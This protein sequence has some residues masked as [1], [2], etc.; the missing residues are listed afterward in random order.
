MPGAPVLFAVP[1]RQGRR[2]RGLFLQNQPVGLP[3]GAEAL[4]QV[5]AAAA[6]QRQY[7]L[8][9]GPGQ[10]HAQLPAHG[11]DQPASDGLVLP[12][13]N[14]DGQDSRAVRGLRREGLRFPAEVLVFLPQQLRRRRDPSRAAGRNLLQQ[15]QDLQAQ[16]VAEEAGILIAL[17]LHVG[18]AVPGHIGV[19]L[20]P[21]GFQEWA[22]DPSPHRGDAAQ[23]LESRSPQKV[24]EGRLGV[25]L[26]VVSGGDAGRAHVTG[27]SIQEGV[28][29]LPG[30]VLD[31][32]ALPGGKV[33]HVPRSAGQGDA[34]LPAPVPDKTLVP[35]RCGP[36]AV[37]EMG[38]GDLKAPLP[39]QGGEKVEH[40]H[41]VPPAGHG[42]QDQAVQH[43]PFSG[44]APD[45]PG[46]RISHLH[47]SAF[48]GC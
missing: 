2:E 14:R 19:D 8:R 24:E 44:E 39:G 46:Q 9:L 43:P 3:D 36:Q 41:R 20:R 40:R 45:P 28:A 48:P 31:A 13:Q 32:Q 22:D 17:I 42:A 25:V 29:Q 18:D 7:R 21:A 27:G 30:R 37:V 12:V 35:A 16:A 5:Q 38:G 47:Q 33:R 4:G 11:A 15:G 6:F 34:L 1:E 23:A 10:L 26:P